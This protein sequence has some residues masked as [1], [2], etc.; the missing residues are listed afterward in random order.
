MRTLFRGVIACWVLLAAGVDRS[1]I[2]STCAQA[3]E[4]SP[5]RYAT[6]DQYETR[7]LEGWPVRIHRNFLAEKPELAAQVLE[8]LAD[9]L[10]GVKRMVPARAVERLQGVTIWVEENEPH[11]PAMCY[12]PDPDWLRE[13]DMNP[14]K[15]LGVEIANARNFLSWIKQQPW[16]V[17]HELAHAYH[18]QFLPD[19]FGNAGV[20]K[21]HEKALGEGLYDGVLH[22]QGQEIEGYG[23]RDPMEYFAEG[24][25]A[26]FGT[27]DFYPFV[28]AELK[29]HDPRLFQLLN[30]LWNQ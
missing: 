23:G 29:R 10:R 30:E 11:H 6:T 20:K 9:Q 1:A 2:D 3:D 19:G 7:R 16:M 8:L 24:S 18:H 21:A 13:H 15:A 5:P 4:P 22:I 17:L 28:S 25:E 26:Y 14:E 27:N 12:H